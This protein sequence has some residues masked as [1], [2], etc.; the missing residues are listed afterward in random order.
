M[1]QVSLQSWSLVKRDVADVVN[2]STLGPYSFQVLVSATWS[3]SNLTNLPIGDRRLPQTFDKS[4]R[5]RKAVKE[6]R[7]AEQRRANR[8]RDDCNMLFTGQ[9]PP[10]IDKNGNNSDSDRSA[11]EEVEAEEIEIN[12]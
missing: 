3:A 11:K 4:T 8:I 12:S 2:S 9:Y 5:K 7:E 10:K 6:L 1:T